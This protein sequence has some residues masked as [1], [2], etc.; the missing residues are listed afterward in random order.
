MRHRD[1][2]LTTLSHVSSYVVAE[3]LC[4]PDGTYIS[5]IANV[6]IV[7]EKVVI[8]DLRNHSRPSIKVP[9]PAHMLREVIRWYIII[10]IVQVIS[11]RHVGCRN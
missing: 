9:T 11:P 1:V 3:K 5:V 4:Q 10:D 8:I 7:F 2:F 6:W